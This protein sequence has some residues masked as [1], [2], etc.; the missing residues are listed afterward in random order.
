MKF[1]VPCVLHEPLSKAYWKLTYPKNSFQ[2]SLAYLTAKKVYLRNRLAEAQNWKC[3]WCGCETVPE[4]SKRNSATIEHVIPRSKG[5]SNDPENLAMSCARCNQHRGTIDA[6]EFMV[7]SLTGFAVI[8]VKDR[9]LAAKLERIKAR[10]EKKRSLVQA[11]NAAIE[12]NNGN[13]FKEGEKA[14]RMFNR[15][16]TSPNMPERLT[17]AA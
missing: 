7:A 15:Y 9:D 6:D 8:K 11:V 16:L 4:S 5:G 10:R 17:L 2:A 3:C 12:A 1:D 14:W 13:P